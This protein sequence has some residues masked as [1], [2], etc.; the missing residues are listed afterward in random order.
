M[1]IDTR[2]SFPRALKLGR[3]GSSSTRVMST[4]VSFKTMFSK[5][6]E[7]FVQQMEAYTMASLR[8]ANVKDRQN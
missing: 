6:K 4:K 2:D 8:T 7:S 1:V 5:G 3:E